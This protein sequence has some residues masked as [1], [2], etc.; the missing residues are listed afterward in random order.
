MA[1]TIT[2]S[3]GSLVIT[4][5]DGQFDNTTSLTLAGPNAVGYGQF[6]DQNIL[7]LL[8]NFASNTSPSGGNVQGQ[9]WFNKSS[10]TLNVF[11]TQGYLPVSGIIIS[12]SQPVNANPGNT[13]YDTSRNQYFFY[14]GTNW[15]L[16]GPNYTR[17]QG[18]SGAIPTSVNDA[19]VA[20]VTHN[21]LE[22]RFGNQLLATL[23][24]DTLFTPSPA[25]PGF[26]QIFTGLTLNNNLFPGSN[27]FYTNANTAA[28]L[29]VDT[30]IIGINNNV[31][32]LTSTVATNLS[33]V[34]ANI[35][36]SNIAMAN[37]V[38]NQI[39]A[40]NSAWSANASIQEIEISGLRANITAANVSWIANAGIQEIEIS[41]LRANI[42]AAN[43]AIALSTSN[44]QSNVASQQTAL[45]SLTAT[46]ATLATVDSPSFTGTPTAPTPV[47]SDNSNLIATT[48]FVR[49]QINNGI[50]SLGTMSVQNSGSVTITGGNITGSYGLNAATA[51]NASYA[52]T[53]NLANYATTANLATY[54]T[55]ANSAT[56]A[57]TANSA[58]YATTAVAAATATNASYAT[59][60]NL[61]NYATT[62]RNGGVNSVNGRTG[63]VNIRG[64]GFNGEVWNNLTGSRSSG[65]AYQNTHGYPI[66]VS[67]WQTNQGD[68]NCQ[69]L[70]GATS[71]SLATV[72]FW[73]AQFNGAG[74]VS[75]I[76]G[77]VVPPG[78]WYAIIT[79]GGGV[80]G[81]WELY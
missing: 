60:A 70:I 18:V 11:T 73:G 3:D 63:V 34:N 69:F 59:T 47:S 56:Y 25:M 16:I 5:P 48:S 46:V 36:F 78:M 30:T 45:N 57:T 64:L 52:T 19:V 32:A 8:E 33:T 1:Y 26:P 58:T 21:I 24:G 55:T 79:Q 37:Y 31:S 27:Q 68:S 13:W 75:G 4:I 29:P 40:T 20:G 62:A 44:W 74:A 67:A 81:W 72:A 77:P 61:A 54:A 71:D 49:S 53:A 2:T 43:N 35:I 28:Y 76:T 42:T 39:S 7:Q 12:T 22:L 17:A 6:L 51:T 80:S 65:T 9:L 38:N 23:N 15:N 50:G 14:D 66:Q 41:S 10:Q